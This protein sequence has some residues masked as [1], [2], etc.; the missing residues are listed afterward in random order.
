MALPVINRI[1][2][3]VLLERKTVS[4]NANKIYA[5][6]RILPGH[7]SLTGWAVPFIM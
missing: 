1:F 4:T 6:N 7:I 3:K 5:M 2:L